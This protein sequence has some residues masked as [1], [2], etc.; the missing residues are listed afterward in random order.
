MREARKRLEEE[1]RKEINEDLIFESYARMRAKEE[2][3]VR[4][5]KRVRRAN[6]RRAQNKQIVKPALNKEQ[7]Y[8][9]TEGVQPAPLPRDIRPFDEIEDL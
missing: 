7:S 6:Q 3:A 5:T 8:Q 9:T 1:G 2:Q 4:E